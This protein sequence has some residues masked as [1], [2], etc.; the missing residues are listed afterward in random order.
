M[1]ATRGDGSL[2]DLTGSQLA[3]VNAL[4]AGGTHEDAAQAAGVH[5]VTVTRWVNHHP[6]FIA[7]L[8][9]ARADLA[10]R[11][12]S[13]IVRVTKLAMEVVEASLEAGDQ[14]AALKWLRIVPPSL[15]ISVVGPTGSVDVIEQVRSGMPSPHEEMISSGHERTTEEAERE[16]ARRLRQASR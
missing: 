12:R 15:T 6:A 8:N 11:T 3:A 16:I 1:S 9:R 13:K 7:E 4:M 10:R 14:E 5:R 2:H